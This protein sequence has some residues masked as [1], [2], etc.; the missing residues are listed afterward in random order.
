M[1]PNQG[2][3]LNGIVTGLFNWS[4]FGLLVLFRRAI[5]HEDIQSFL[6]HTDRRGKQLLAEGITAGTLSFAAYLLVLM[7]S[8][9]GTLAVAWDTFYSTV[10]L[11]GTGGFG[12]LAVAVF[13]EALFRGY[14]LPKLLKYS[15]SVAIGLLSVLFGIFH[16]TSYPANNLIWLGV[17][18]VCLFGVVC[19]IAVIGS[20][21]LM[22]AVGYHFAWNLTQSVLL[23]NQVDSVS[24]L[25]NLQVKEGF[26]AGASFTPE[27]GMV[28]T[29]VWAAVGLYTF[30][31]FHRRGI[32]TQPASSGAG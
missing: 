23:M 11:L 9:Q 1:E 21:S 7:L 20:H 31:R 10:A 5:H 19:S 22:W 2:V 29:A 13:E 4:L 27:S 16:L 3:F 15:K 6:F 8:G 12:F 18:N 17:L 32:P 30:T 26:W 25:L 24:T 28:V 14:L